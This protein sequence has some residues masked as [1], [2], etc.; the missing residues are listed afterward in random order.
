[1]QLLAGQVVATRF[2]DRRESVLRPSIH[3]YQTPAL[4]AVS[5]LCAT[6][7]AAR[8]LT[9]SQP[10]ANRRC[11]RRLSTLRPTRICGAAAIDRY[12]NLEAPTRA[13]KPPYLITAMARLLTLAALPSYFA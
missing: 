3:G 5:D 6:R 2:P 8:L 9:A 11:I 13:I 1:M 12:Q 4:H 10:F 7:S